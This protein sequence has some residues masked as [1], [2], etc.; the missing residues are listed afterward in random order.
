ASSF[1]DWPGRFGPG[2]ALVA[3][4]PPGR[5]ER[6][7]EPPFT[8]LQPLVGAALAALRPHLTPPYAFF[9]HSM[10]ALLAF[11]VARQ[12]PLL[13]CPTPVQ[14]IVSGRAAPTRT[15]CPRSATPATDAELLAWLRAYRGTPETVL[16]NEQLLQF[17]LP[18]L[19]ADFTVCATYRFEPGE[20]LSCPLTALGGL[21]DP[22]V[23]ADDLH[24]WREQ[25]SAVFMA[26]R[27]PGDHFYLKTC[28]E[29]FPVLSNILA[30][31]QCTVHL[32]FANLELPP[33][34]VDGLAAVCSGEEQ[35]RA[36]R[37]L[38]A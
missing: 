10:G 18:A 38:R 15:G 2:V 1:R 30:G 28:P 3:V 4:Q 17:L 9:G 33:V 22:E 25:T 36:E 12:L 35:R 14:V 8:R 7:A 27:F 13:G 23:S 37:F 32:W 5:E 31:T 24:D 11:E 29:F 20:P 26:R 34:V 21:D 16:A 19:R 6:A